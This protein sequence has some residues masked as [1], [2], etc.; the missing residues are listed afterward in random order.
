MPT[1]SGGC[2]NGPNLRLSGISFRRQSGQPGK[3]KTAKKPQPV[4]RLRNNIKSVRNIIEI[5]V[6]KLAPKEMTDLLADMASRTQLIH[7][8]LDRQANEASRISAEKETAA[9]KKVLL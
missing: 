9:K 6:F 3:A 2:Q 7:Q 4:Q 8:E 5:Q 1:D